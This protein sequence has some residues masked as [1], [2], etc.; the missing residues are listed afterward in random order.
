MKKK[1]LSVMMG[2]FM[3]SSLLA[4]CG[5]SEGDTAGQADSSTQEVST[6]ET[7]KEESKEQQATEGT[8]AT[9][10][11]DDYKYYFSFDEEDERVHAAIQ[12][13]AATPI[14]QTTDDAVNYVNGVSG[15][16][17]YV[18]GSKG[19]K[20]DVNG[21]GDTYSVSFWVY[22]ERSANYMPTLQYGPD[23]HG[24]ATGGQHYVNFT[25]AD[26]NP[27][28]SAFPCVWAYDQLDDAKWPNWY[29]D[30]ANTHVGEWNNI[31]LTVDPSELSEDGTLIVAHLYFNGEELVGYDSDGNVR[32]TYVVSGT[33]AESDNF[34]FLLGIN[35][36]DAIMKGAFDEIY[37]YDYV[38]DAGQIKALYE[39]GDATSTYDAPTHEVTLKVDE[40]AID[41]VGAT[42]FS[43][44]WWS[45]WS[46]F[47]ELKDGETKV[48]KLK[49]WSDGVN[50]YDNYTVLFTNEKT[51]AHEDPNE[52]GSA[53]HKEY[54]CVR[55]DAFG[56]TP[57]GDI[58]S[59]LFNYSWGNW[60]TWL[61][62]VMTEADV[63]LTISRS[64]SELTVNAVQTDYLGSANTC[65][66]TFPADIT[67]DDDCFFAITGEACYIDILSIEDAISVVA[68]PDAIDSVGSTDLTNAWWTDWST[69]IEIADGTT[70]TV[71]FKNY[72]DGVNNWDNYVMVFTNEETEAHQ[73][74]NPDEGVGSADHVEYA[75]IRADAYGW[76]VDIDGG[77]VTYETSWGDDWATWLDAMKDADVTL[78]ITRDGTSMVVDAVIVD[79][80]GNKFTSKTSWTTTCAAGDPMYMLLTCEECYIDI[81]SVETK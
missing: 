74:P 33:M 25:W 3:T 18:D 58:D 5:S 53:D 17:L 62:Q 37:V 14:V 43:N 65:Q 56:W 61:Q 64:G 66:V 47:T 68:D 9:E 57:D 32:P 36:W 71:N 75:A 31:T 81:M 55:A 54:A 39:A 15:N 12:D 52:S 45:D 40:S 70:T 72:S 38:L 50:N 22:S 30:E 28:G 8:A 44:A 4:G 69:P 27:D 80:N 60:G 2:V 41:S 26:W 29:P 34:D 21:V 59:A 73:N 7:A 13:T 46:E 76:D 63:E 1:V 19:A 16:A 6:Q 20:L 78:T 48:V 35:Y 42:D 77:D 49:N 67:A 24:D 10:I 79:R 11:P 23:I 51:P